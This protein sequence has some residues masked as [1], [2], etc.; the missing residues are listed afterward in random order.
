[1][2]EDIGLLDF[3]GVENAGAP[4]HMDDMEV[5]PIVI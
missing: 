4:T 2:E 1:V 5:L 3:N